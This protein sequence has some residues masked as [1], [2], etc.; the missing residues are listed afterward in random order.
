VAGMSSEDDTEPL[1]D[2]KLY[3]YSSPDIRALGTGDIYLAG[4]LGEAGLVIM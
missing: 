3:R 2:P 4:I 1:P